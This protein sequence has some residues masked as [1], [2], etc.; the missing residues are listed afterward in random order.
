MGDNANCQVKPLAKLICFKFHFGTLTSCTCRVWH[1]HLACDSNTFLT[2]PLNSSCRNNPKNAVNLGFKGCSLA[3]KILCRSK[4]DFRIHF[5]KLCT[6]DKWQA[7]LAKLCAIPHPG[8]LCECSFGTLKTCIG[9]VW[10]ARIAGIIKLWFLSRVHNCHICRKHALNLGF[11]GVGLDLQALRRSKK[12]FLISHGKT[13]HADTSHAILATPAAKDYRKELGKTI[14]HT[15]ELQR[16]LPLR[17]IRIGEADNPGP[18]NMTTIEHA[19]FAAVNPTSLLNKAD[20]WNTLVQTYGVHVIACAENSATEHVQT[21]MTPFFQKLGMKTIWSE[22]VPKHRQKPADRPK[23]GPALRGKAGGT[24]FHSKWPI[25]PGIGVL[26]NHEFARDRIVHAIIRIGTIHAQI[27]GI[28][29]VTSSAKGHKEMNEKIFREALRVI[30]AISLPSILIG[31]FN[32]D[33]TTNIHF[34]PLL[35]KGF[36]PLQSLYQK[37]YGVSMPNTCKGA[38]IPDTAILHLVWPFCMGL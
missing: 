13:C 32:V 5:E 24:S 38:T 31:D 19:R 26:K 10:Y 22:P 33:V 6:V 37:L 16:S 18:K 7:T 8:E 21:T 29:G 2:L 4:K 34:Q 36:L 30:D 17:G 11:L 3:Q 14:V 9:R 35:Q 27:V 1:S 23:E 12:D 15:C 25:R 20:S 28:Y